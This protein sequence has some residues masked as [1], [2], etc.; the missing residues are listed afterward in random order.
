MT[1][2]MLRRDDSW[3]PLA[4]GQRVYPCMSPIPKP[5][6]RIHRW[7]RSATGYLRQGE[8][9]RMQTAWD[10]RKASL[11]GV[12]AHGILGRCA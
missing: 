9:R 11:V 5:A 2:M 6:P 8:R 12:Q 4:L 3:Q 10:K 7:W 1:K